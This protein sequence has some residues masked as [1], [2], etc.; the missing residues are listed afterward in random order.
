MIKKISIYLLVLTFLIQNLHAKDIKVIVPL[1]AGSLTDL[2]AKAVGEAYQKVSGDTWAIEYQVGGNGAVAATKFQQSAPNTVLWGIATIH[3]YEPAFK[4]N[5]PYKDE[6]FKHMAFVG[7]TP[8]LY[9]SRPASGIKT[10]EDMLTVL[11][12]SKKPFIG[13]YSSGQQVNLAL[14]QEK[15][16]MAK[17]VQTVGHKAAPE[18]LLNILNGSIDVGIVG[19][20]AEVFQLATEGKLN[21]IGTTRGEDYQ[22]QS[23]KIRSIEKAT[24]VKQIDGGYQV[25]IKPNADQKFVDEFSANLQ[26][27]LNSKELND[28][29]LKHHVYPANIFGTEGTE[30]M[31]KEWRGILKSYRHLIAS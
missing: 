22:V 8:V 9:V 29:M 3:V 13:T 6:D 4:D 7:I 1:S 14:L 24:G 16:K 28:W 25:S 12:K 2:T 15:G 26:K 21:I 18:V 20:T 5:L 30:K 23:F 10:I 19:H 31:I 27:A 17:N 11:P